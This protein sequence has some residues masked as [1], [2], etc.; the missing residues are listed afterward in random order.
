M[1]KMFLL[2]SLMAFV[3]QLSSHSITTTLF[4]EIMTKPT[5]GFDIFPTENVG[6][7][8]AWFPDLGLT[9]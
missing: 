4:R 2:P 5:Q 6:H 8:A 3:G 1:K 7:G 9:K